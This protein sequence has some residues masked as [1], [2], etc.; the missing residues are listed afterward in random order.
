MVRPDLLL[1]ATEESI[2]RFLQQ[3]ESISKNGSLRRAR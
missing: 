1:L 3:D 2:A